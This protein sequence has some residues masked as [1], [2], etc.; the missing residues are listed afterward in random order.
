MQYS[1]LRCHKMQ[2]RESVVNRIDYGDIS[3]IRTYIHACIL[4]AKIQNLTIKIF[5]PVSDYPVLLFS[6]FLSIVAI[7]LK[8]FT[9]PCIENAARMSLVVRICLLISNLKCR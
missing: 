7:K 1:L 5:A 8:E 3:C 4:S 2:T 9:L 6:F